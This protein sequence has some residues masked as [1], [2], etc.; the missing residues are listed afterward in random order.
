MGFVLAADPPVLHRDLK[1]ANLLLDTSY[2]VKIC[3]F[4]LARLKAYTN[5]HTGNTGTTQWMAPEVL[6]NERYG[7]KADVYSFGVIMWEIITRECPFEGMSQIQVAVK[8]LN[9]RGRVVV[10]DWC[11]RGCPKLSALVEKTL[12]ANPVLRPTFEQILEVVKLL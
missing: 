12:E 9:E 11:R 5:S 6:R 8:V 4:G 10:P 1:S 7:E 3:D 2:D